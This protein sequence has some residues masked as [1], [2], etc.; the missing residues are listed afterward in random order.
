MRGLKVLFLCL[1]VI[2]SQLTL[3]SGQ[4]EVPKKKLLVKAEEH[5]YD[6]DFKSALPLYR[7]LY[8]SNPR[9]PMANFALGVSY[10]HLAPNITEGINK[11]KAI[12]HLE[13]C[14]KEQYLVDVSYFL[15]RAY[16]LTYQFKKAQFYYKEYLD[17]LPTHELYYLMPIMSKEK[18]IADVRRKI[19]MCDNGIVL[20]SDTVSVVFENMGI[21]I[22][23]SFPDYAPAISADNEVLIFT[24]RMPRKDK[25]EKMTYDYLY[26][27]DVYI[28]YNKKGVWM[29]AVLISDN[30]NTKKHDASIGLSSDAQSLFTYYRGDIYRSRLEGLTWGKPKK[31]GKEIN[32][33]AW[34]T[35]ISITSAQNTIYFVSDRKGGYG[36]RDIYKAKLMPDGEWGEVQNL[37][38][39]INTKYDEEAPFIHPDDRHLY[40]SSKG[41][42]SMGGFDI[43]FTIRTDDSWSKPKNMGHPI[44]TPDDDIYFTVSANGRN[45]YLSTIRDGGLGEKD[46]YIAYMPDTGE[47]PLVVIRGMIKG[48]N[49][50]PISAQFAVKDLK[51]GELVGIYSSNSATGKYLLVFPPGRDYDLVISAENFVPH[52]EQIHIPD[53]NRF[54]DLFQEIQ[55]TS[56][57]GIDVIT[58]RDTTLGQKIFVRNAFFDIDS[59]VSV[60][61]AALLKTDVKE[62]AYSAF[63]GKLEKAEDKASISKRLQK[64]EGIGNSIAE[65]EPVEQVHITNP[66]IQSDLDQIIINYDTLYATSPTSHTRVEMADLAALG[67]TVKETMYITAEQLDTTTIRPEL[68]FSMKGYNEGLDEIVADTIEADGEEDVYISMADLTDTADESELQ[69]KPAT[70]SEGEDEKEQSADSKTVAVDA[71]DETGAEPLNE[72]V[73]KERVAEEEMAESTVIDEQLHTS[74]E[75]DETTETKPET[76]SDNSLTLSSSVSVEGSISAEVKNKEELIPE[77][78]LSDK[79]ASAVATQ[80]TGSI[81]KGDLLVSEAAMCLLVSERTPVNIAETFGSDVKKIYCY[82]DIGLEPREKSTVH[83]IWYYNGLEMADVELNVQG[84]RWRTWSSKNIY[85]SWVGEW[86][87]DITNSDKKVLQSI[88]F[89]IDKR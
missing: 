7:T 17:S 66:L 6:G 12:P 5:F 4:N 21:K 24:S 56:A 86:R 58:G 62:I 3:V 89:T 50:K 85:R 44:N 42:N 83:H 74:G 70:S 84:P 88:K 33:S 37:G 81:A 31:L 34:E 2:L 47:V 39:T 36:G 49:G 22:N 82:T 79:V 63:L 67:I 68:Y 46:L 64:I 13:F 29:D 60:I 48:D 53:Q 23:S 14:R 65:Y 20:T 57:T 30:I 15:A 78:P 9:D 41:H 32:T 26:Y 55:L 11:D 38:A 19:E 54:Y 61:D 80:Q 69:D 59:A 35:H 1:L 43:F 16:H 45:G 25:T 87:V 18:Q 71:E 75:T 8:S 72:E 10:I 77:K 27:E 52:R 40:F 76:A 28:S 73:I 51:S